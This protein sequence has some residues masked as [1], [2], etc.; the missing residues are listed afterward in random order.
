MMP[1]Y[2]FDDK[3]TLVQ[4]MTSV[5]RKQAFTWTNSNPDPSP[6]R[7]FEEH[8]ELITNG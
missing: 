3:S 8:S 6:Y 7:P 4:I 1:Q 2:T 5:V